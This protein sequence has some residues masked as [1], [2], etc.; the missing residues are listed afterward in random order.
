M[1]GTQAGCRH[2]ERVHAYLDNLNRLG[3]IWFSKRPIDDPAAYQVLEAQPG[4]L[5]AVR[6]AS[7]AKT[8]QRS[9]GLTPF[10]AEPT[11]PFDAQRHERDDG[12]GPP[13][14]CHSVGGLVSHFCN[15]RR[16]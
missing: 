9:I 5:E 4:V 3:L 2:P 11:E 7:R 13:G 16:Q 1:I 15:V 14:Q 6:S 12:K 10:I 8:T